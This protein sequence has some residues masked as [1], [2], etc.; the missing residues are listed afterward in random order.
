MK[1]TSFT[2]YSLRVLI[3]L[4]SEPGRRAT[5]AEI[6]TAFAVSENH[7]TKVV[8]FLGQA[9]WVVTVR[10][11]GGGLGLAREAGEIVVGDV[12]RQTEGAAMP[13]E[14]FDQAGST[15]TIARVCRLHGVLGEAADAFHAVLDKY[16]LEDLVHN[17][18]TLSRM[19]FIGRER[20][21]AASRRLAT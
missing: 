10:G 8:H 2:D 21:P 5:I 9:G 4:A 15:C 11:K 16:T 19:L 17:R 14:C 12:V 7:L 6:A 18:A 13:A 20:P 3:Y 1:L